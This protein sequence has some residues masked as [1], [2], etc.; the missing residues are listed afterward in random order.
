MA[1]GIAQLLAEQFA[2]RHQ[3]TDSVVPFQGHPDLD[4]RCLICLETFR[5]NSNNLVTHKNLA[6]GIVAQH[7]PLH[8]VC[9]NN[10]LEQRA[11]CPYPCPEK[12]EL[13][14]LATRASR[15]V[16]RNILGAASAFGGAATMYSILPPPDNSINDV[17]RVAL[18]CA[19]PYATIK[20]IE[21]RGLDLQEALPREE[22]KDFFYFADLM[23]ISGAVL[24]SLQQPSTNRWIVGAG[25]VGAIS[26]TNT[27]HA[28]RMKQ[29]PF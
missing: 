4:D 8:E 27:I 23:I 3:Q 16:G 11:D 10:L 24:Y 13:H 21:S 2:S 7:A 17:A 26:L 6:T 25:A 5:D 28:L 9:F 18:I 15:I 19:A 14:S 22:K 20:L 12:I 1:F 29:S